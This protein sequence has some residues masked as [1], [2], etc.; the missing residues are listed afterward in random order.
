M[1]IEDFILGTLEIFLF[2]FLLDQFET[3]GVETEAGEGGQ[4]F[5]GQTEISTIKY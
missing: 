5:I 4:I 1:C 2:Y 3:E